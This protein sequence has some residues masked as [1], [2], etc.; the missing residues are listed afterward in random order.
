MGKLILCMENYFTLN[1]FDML[2]N[3]FLLYIGNK[4]YKIYN[5]L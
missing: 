4:N 5:L 3:L 2:A 1:F